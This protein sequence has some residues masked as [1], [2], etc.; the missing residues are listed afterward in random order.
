M[1]K[2]VGMSVEN[3]QNPWPRFCFVYAALAFCNLYFMTLFYLKKM[4]DFKNI[5]KVNIRTNLFF[6]FKNVLFKIDHEKCMMTNG[7]IWFLYGEN[8]N[9]SDI[10]YQYKV[11]ILIHYQ[12]GRST[13]L[14]MVKILRKRSLA[15]WLHHIFTWKQ[16]SLK[17]ILYHATRIIASL[18]ILLND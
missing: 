1:W 13:D 3:L 11:I 8:N 4:L 12:S 5:R 9:L 15:H 17:C 16:G 10:W 18:K 2:V 14:Q 6:F 7:R